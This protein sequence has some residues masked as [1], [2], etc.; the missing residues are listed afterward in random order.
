MVAR[1]KR[2]LMTSLFPMGFLLW[3]STAYICGSYADKSLLTDMEEW[4]AHEINH[5][6]GESIFEL[7]WTLTPQP[8]GNSFSKLYCYDVFTYFFSA[9]IEKDLFDPF[10]KIRSLKDLASVA[11][12]ALPQFVRQ[13]LI[14]RAFVA[15]Q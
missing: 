2:I 13:Y 3:N 7:S 15:L 12:V 5:F 4:N 9:D 1:D 14:F 6:G 10:N 8:R 11:D